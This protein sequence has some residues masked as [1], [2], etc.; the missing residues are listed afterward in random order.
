MECCCGDPYGF[1]GSGLNGDLW[2]GGFCARFSLLQNGILLD[3]EVE[4]QALFICPPWMGGICYI[5][6][7]YTVEPWIYEV[8]DIRYV[9]TFT[10]SC[11]D[12]PC[13]TLQIAV[14]QQIP[15]GSGN[16]AFIRNDI[17]YSIGDLTPVP[18][19][20]GMWASYACLGSNVYTAI[21]PFVYDPPDVISLVPF[22]AIFP[23]GSWFNTISL[24]NGAGL[25]PA[26]FISGIGFQCPP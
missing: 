26:T 8:G 14:W 22:D 7:Y 16:W 9:I 24:G 11:G 15:S 12:P 4:M 19:S 20:P 1:C 6:H 18:G 25:V 13:G 10:M 21:V 3:V 23:P 17:Y 2:P 5:D